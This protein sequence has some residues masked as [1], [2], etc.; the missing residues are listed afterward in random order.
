MNKLVE[1]LI[2]WTPHSCAF[3]TDIEK[4]YNAVLLQPSHWHYQMYLWRD[5]VERSAHRKVIKTLIHGVRSSGGLAECGLRKT[6]E[7]MK[8]V[9]HNACNVIIH[10]I[11]IDDCL[12]GD[13]TYEHA[14]TITDHLKID[15]EQGGFTLKGFTFS[16]HD[17]PP[18]LTNDGESVTVGGLK[19]FPKG[20]FFFINCGELN[21]FKKCR[22]RKTPHMNGVI[23]EQLF[24]KRDCEKGSR[25]I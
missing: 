16:G 14:L 23:P 6:A 5:D 21:F 12:L 24:S 20:D 10:D 3:H 9:Y 22:G 8:S 19:W 18:H 4:M 1:I 17:P 13:C 15:L 7:L 2:R 25:N 11:Y